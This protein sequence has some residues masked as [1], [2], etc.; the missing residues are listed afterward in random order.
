MT[1]S[2]QP[3]QPG[4]YIGLMS[5][6]SLDGVDG[7]L[8]NFLDPENLELEAHVHLPFAPEL[9]QHLLNLNSPANNEIE[10][11][12]MAAID[13]ARL[14][15]GNVA[16]LLQQTGLSASDIRAV[17]CHGQTIRHRPD[18]GFTLQIGNPAWLAELCGI[19]VVADFRSRDIAAGGQGAPLVPAFHRAVFAH[20]LKH[21]VIVNIGGISN[22]TNLPPHGPV[23][24]FDCGP[25]NILMDGWILRH[26]GLAFDEGGR[27][28]SG[29]KVIPD[30]LV[31]LLDDTFFHQSPPKST[32][33]D[34]F[35]PGWLEARLPPGYAA[36]D[37]QATLLELSAS[38]I[39]GDILKHCSG[40]EEIFLCGG[41][42]RNQALVERLRGM[43]PQAGIASTG[44]L[45]LD[46]D[47][48]E[49]AAFAWL[50]MQCLSGRPGNL[51]RVT[52]ARGPRILGAIYQA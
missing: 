23:S 11:A 40:A 3:G 44:V 29:G 45:G 38:C 50:A 10:C 37:V 14:Y 26:C 46:T 28:A 19:D 39:A 5:G 7:V 42:A 18:L 33:R 34:Q 25:G 49:S 27:W 52:G 1:D 12:G 8:V 21:R 20:P 32:G 4:R 30:L 48:V 16:A 41:G 51:P 43:L 22:L 47:H 24:G 13:L 31:R 9:K 36:I 17:G 6:T 2:L 15:A 35:N